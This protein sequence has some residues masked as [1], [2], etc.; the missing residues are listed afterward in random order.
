MINSTE[1]KKYKYLSDEFKN[2]IKIS[3]NLVFKLQKYSQEEVDKQ[4]VTSNKLF[5]AMLVNKR[6]KNR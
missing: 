3:K 6:G 2:T 1:D 4:A 5:I